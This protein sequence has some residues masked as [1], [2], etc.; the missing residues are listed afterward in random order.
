MQS[1]D[2]SKN[3]LPGDDIGGSSENWSRKRT[4]SVSTLSSEVLVFTVL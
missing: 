3:A 1:S 2:Q 4:N